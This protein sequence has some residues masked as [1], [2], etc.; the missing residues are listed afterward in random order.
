MPTKN[1]HADQAEAQAQARWGAGWSGLSQ[2]QKAGAIALA[3]VGIINGQ[4]IVEGSEA[5]QLQR[6]LE[7]ADQVAARF[8]S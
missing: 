1:R 6:L 3:W 4:E 7:G 2:E 8:Q 5:S